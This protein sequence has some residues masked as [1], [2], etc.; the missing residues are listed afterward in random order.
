MV[1]RKGKHMRNIG[2]NTS[3]NKEKLKRANYVL[4]QLHC[5]HRCLLGHGFCPYEKRCDYVCSIIVKY[6]NKFRNV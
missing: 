6:Q 2:K 1:H 4:G 5:S 3:N